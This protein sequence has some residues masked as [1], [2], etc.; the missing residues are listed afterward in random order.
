MVMA[1][2]TQEAS[3][4]T[5]L[6]QA[7]VE[8]QHEYGTTDH[9]PEDKPRM[10][11]VLWFSLAAGVFLAAFDSTVVASLLAHIASDLGNFRAVPWIG[12][13]YLISSAAFQPLFGKLTDIFGRRA[14]LVTCNIVFALG[15]VACALS[16]TVPA[17]ILSRFFQGIGGGGLTALSVIT[18][19]DLVSARDRG[20]YQGFGNITFGIG[21]SMGAAMGGLINDYWGW[22]AVFMIQAPFVLVSLGLV[23]LNLHLPVPSSHETH[24]TKI[25]RIDFLGSFTLSSSL[26]CLLV[27]LSIGGESYAWSSPQVLGMF[28]VDASL[29]FAFIYVELRVAKEPIIHLEL[30]RDPT[31]TFS[32]LS[33]LFSSMITFSLLFYVPIFL[34][35]VMVLPPSTAGL[36]LLGY[37]CGVATGSLTSGLL[38]KKTGTYKRL[39]VGGNIVQ[40]LATLS[41]SGFNE[42]TSVV[43]QIISVY[44]VALSGVNLLTVTLIALITSVPPEMQAIAT[45]IQYC[46]RGIG[47]TTGVTVSS[48]IFQNVL[49]PSLEK[50]VQGVPHR[51]EIIERVISST[52]EIGKLEGA[53]RRMVIHAYQDASTSV[54]YFTLFLATLVFVVGLPIRQNSLDRAKN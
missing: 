7:D 32:G 40:L 39:L 31:I 41:I 28:F 24:W 26:V 27:T 10:T 13:A 30:F 12:T 35:S 34:E 33:A 11:L 38:M 44:L 49:R 2:D 19:S 1:A 16:P 5:S 51:R 14:G 9:V 25:K 18:I 54:F 23:L 3:D 17:L 15:C 50:Y 37:F 21:A 29:V 48:A 6:L 8:Q 4:T 20:V 43:R 52:D 46:A 45:S 53:V 36:R 22:R 42:N 47:T